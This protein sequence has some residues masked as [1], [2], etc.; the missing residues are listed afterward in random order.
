MVGHCADMPAAYLLSDVAIAP[1]LAPEAFGRTAVEPQMMGRPVIAADHGAAR[2]TVVPGQTGWLARPGDVDDWTRTL[3]EAIGAGA[4]RR[5][6]MG[7]AAM[8]RARALYSVE[9]MAQATL[10]VYA[11]VMARRP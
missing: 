4:E 9:A 2:E 11:D 7:R 8:A 3:G 5:S 1:S 10:K 6:A